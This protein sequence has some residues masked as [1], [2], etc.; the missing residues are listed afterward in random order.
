MKLI[1][2]VSRKKMNRWQASCPS[3]PGCGACGRTLNEAVERIDPAVRGY[4]ASLNVAAPRKLE[5]IVR[6]AT[7]WRPS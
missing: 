3:L 4:L 6:V 1:V 7:A 2:R 5:K